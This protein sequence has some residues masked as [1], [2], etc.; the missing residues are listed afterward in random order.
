[1]P[2]ADV[3]NFPCFAIFNFIFIPQIPVELQ[4]N[5][6]SFDASQGYLLALPLAFIYVSSLSR[7]LPINP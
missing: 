1:M 6:A 7:W 4:L 2:R 5:A 3:K